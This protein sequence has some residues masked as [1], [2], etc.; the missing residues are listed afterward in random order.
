MKNIILLIL[1]MSLGIQAQDKIL[2]PKLENCAWIAGNWKGEAFGGQVEENWSE[3][4]GG[5]MMATFKLI[6][7][8]KVSFYEIEII[9]QLDTTLVLQLKHFD[10][11]LK[12][13]E[14]KDE[15]VDFPLRKITANK[16]IFEGMTFERVS[17]NEMNVLVDIKNDTGDINVMTFNYHRAKPINKLTEVKKAKQA[18]II[19][20][21]M[22]DP[23]WSETKWLPIDQTWIGDQPT[24]SDFSGRYKL[25]WTED[26]LFLLAEI[27]DD[28]LLDNFENPLERWWDEDCVE[29][30]IDENNSGGNHQY[31]HS[32]FAYHVSL[33]GD[34][35]DVDESKNGILFNDHVESKRVTNGTTSTWEFKINLYDDTFKEQSQ[36]KPIL[37]KANK[38]VGFALAYCDNDS[39]EHRENFI[40]SEVVVGVDKDRGWKDA[41]IFGTLILV[42]NE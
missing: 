34:V 21:K 39:S 4:S 9:R 38:R 31:N 35:V 16:V 28:V 37:L 11:A 17:D 32:A 15:T 26:G 36:N 23:I 29:I 18:P 10:G 19:D 1:F 25:S 24:D 22:D 13:W 12:G 8:N 41:N 27:E 14:T 5:S 3:P 2:E 42:D 40:G 33:D 30:F 20:G 6:N 7:D